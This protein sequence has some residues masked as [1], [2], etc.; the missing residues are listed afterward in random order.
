MNQLHCTNF[1]DNFVYLA[2]YKPLKLRFHAVFKGVHKFQAVS[3]SDV[4]NN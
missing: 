1:V 4:K 2:R 3:L